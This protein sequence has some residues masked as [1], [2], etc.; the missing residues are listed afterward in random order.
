LIGGARGTVANVHKGVTMWD[1]PACENIARMT[2]YRFVVCV[3]SVSA[4]R[5]MGGGR[6]SHA[7]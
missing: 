5:L 3:S 4:A 6:T 1:T 7:D 2:A